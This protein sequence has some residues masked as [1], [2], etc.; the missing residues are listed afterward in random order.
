[1]SPGTQHSGFAQHESNG[2]GA[3]IGGVEMSA[4]TS[5]SA[6][7]FTDDFV[8]SGDG[9]LDAWRRMGRSDSTTVHKFDSVAFTVYVIRCVAH[10]LLLAS[11]QQENSEK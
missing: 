6:I 4:V 2:S 3:V 8:S 7:G 5:S 9:A 1:M 10:L 11:Q